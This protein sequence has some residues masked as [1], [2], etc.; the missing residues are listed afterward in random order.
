MALMVNIVIYED[1]YGCMDDVWSFKM[2][3]QGN[4]KD[5]KVDG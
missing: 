2:V 1:E 3:E 4:Q 5:A